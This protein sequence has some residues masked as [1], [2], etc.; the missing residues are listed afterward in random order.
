MPFS[1]PNSTGGSTR[2]L[3]VSVNK[4]DGTGSAAGVN[5]YPNDLAVGE[6]FA[7]R[8]DMFL[9]F[10]SAAAGTTEHAIFGINHSGTRTNR[11]L[12]AGG[13]IGG[14][15]MW[16]AIETDGSA[17]SS[18]RSYALFGATSDTAA[19]PFTSA[20]AR[21]F[22]SF[23]TAPPFIGIPG[24]SPAGQWADVELSQ[25]RVGDS[26]VV[27]LVVNDVTI[28]SRTNNTPRTSGTVMLGHMDSFNSIGSTNNFTI[29]DN[30]R[31]INFTAAPLQITS[32][33]R[34]GADVVVE[35]SAD[36][37]LTANDFTLESTT[38]LPGGFNADP[39]AT[40]TA[41]GGGKF[42]AVSPNSADAQR[43]YR[44]RR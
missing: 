5:I 35:F 23:F 39:G 8:F 29:Y 6:D 19:P 3:R 40:I 34:S 42:R 26:L 22:D 15:G 25:R 37:S 31:V 44:V 24:G 10:S 13:T 17:S 20:S 41:L 33:S 9:T 4:N 28:V 7:L 14:D 32:I 38:A 27:T 36:A 43:F 16:A 1:A 11:A 12:S 21:S 2:G 30:V 18:G